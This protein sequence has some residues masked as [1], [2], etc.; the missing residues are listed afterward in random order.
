MLARVRRYHASLGYKLNKRWRMYDEEKPVFLSVNGMRLT[1]DSVF[2]FIDEAWK[3]QG[4][5]PATVSPHRLRHGT[6]YSVLR[7][8]LG[9]TLLDK[10]LTVKSMFGH[11]RITTTEMYADIPVAVLESLCGDRQAK[12]KHVEAEEIYQA[13]YLPEH[14]HVEKRGHRK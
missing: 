3:R 12:I 2:K 4:G 6:A 14:K 11:E 9:K 13:T 8:E 5:S 10:L 1:P 7:S